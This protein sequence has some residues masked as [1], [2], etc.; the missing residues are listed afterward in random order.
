MDRNDLELH[1]LACEIAADDGRVY[2]D[3]LENAR[4][5][6]YG[7]QQYADA[8]DAS[9]QAERL[10]IQDGLSGG[11]SS[12]DRPSPRGRIVPMA[13]TILAPPLIITLEE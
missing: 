6:W 2:A 10:D 4:Q 13:P 11:L 9:A 5:E 7:L 12:S 3:A 8:W 1:A